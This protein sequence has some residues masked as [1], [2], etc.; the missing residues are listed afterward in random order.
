MNIVL[1]TVSIFLRFVLYLIFHLQKST[2]HQTQANVMRVLQNLANFFQLLQTLSQSLGSQSTFFPPTPQIDNNQSDLCRSMSK[3]PFV[4]YTFQGHLLLDCLLSTFK[5]TCT[6]FISQ[7]SFLGQGQCST[8]GVTISWQKTWENLI[9]TN[10]NLLLPW[11][12]DA[13]FL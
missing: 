8:G 11:K 3:S 9:M 4:I 13:V 2:I 10:M 1:F 7:H 5:A 6:L 12:I